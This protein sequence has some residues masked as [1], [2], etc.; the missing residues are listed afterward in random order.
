[1]GLMGPMGPIYLICPMGLMSGCNEKGPDVLAPGPSFYYLELMIT[2]CR[3][4]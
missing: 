1:M 2:S 4:R 3:Y